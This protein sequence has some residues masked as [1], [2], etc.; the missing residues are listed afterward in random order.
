MGELAGLRVRAVAEGEGRVVSD[1]DDGFAGLI[2]RKAVPAQAEIERVAVCDLKGGIPLRIVPQI[3]IG[4]VVG[5]VCDVAHAV[6]CR[7]GHIGARARMAVDVLMSRAADGMLVGQLALDQHQRIILLPHAVTRACIGGEPFRIISC[8]RIALRRFS[9]GGITAVRCGQPARV[10]GHADAG[11]AAQAALTDKGPTFSINLI[12]VEVNIVHCAVRVFVLRDDRCAGQ[13]NVGVDIRIHAAAIAAA[14]CRVAADGAAGHGEAAVF[15]IH[16]AAVMAGTVSGDRAAG[17][18]KA[19]STGLHIHT[20]AVAR[21]FVAADAA[22]VH[23]EAGVGAKMD[24][25]A[26]FYRSVV[27]FVTAD[28]AA[29]EHKIGFPSSVTIFDPHAA[30]GIPGRTVHAVRDSA[31]ILAVAERKG[32]ASVHANGTIII[33]ILHVHADAIP[34]QAQYHAILG[35]P[36][37]GPRHRTGQVVISLLHVIGQLRNTNPVSQGRSMLIAARVAADGVVCVLSAPLCGQRHLRRQLLAERLVPRHVQ[38]R[39]LLLRQRR[40]RLIEVGQ[41]RRDLLGVIRRHLVRQGV[42]EGLRGPHRLRRPL[43]L[44]GGVLTGGVD[45][46]CACLLCQCRRGQHGKAERQRHEQTQYSFLHV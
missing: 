7:P 3:D 20:A 26:K 4:G 9:N 29:V 39:Q 43:A 8:D 25:R 28:A 13:G 33:T 41:L 18:G 23:G 15:H 14:A 5:I 30:A 2:F 44:H 27:I 36:R 45:I 24:A 10:H 38:R 34:I 11:G 12:L 22:A 6:P 42:D 35:I 19:G 1:L 37:T 46:R 16:T 17:H 40:Q 31:F 21:S 32:H